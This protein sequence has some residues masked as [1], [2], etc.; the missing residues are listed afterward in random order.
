VEVVHI[1]RAEADEVLNLAENHFRDLKAKEI[2]PAKLSQS[3]SAFAN[4]S[5]GEIY[6]GIG[7]R[8][9]ASAGD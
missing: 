5:G 9:T 8:T 3:V 2:K 7:E 1:S 6:I 4:S